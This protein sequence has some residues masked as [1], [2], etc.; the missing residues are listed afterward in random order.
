MEEIKNSLQDHSM[1]ASKDKSFSFASLLNSDNN[2]EKNNENISKPLHLETFQLQINNEANNFPQ[3][4][5]ERS[6]KNDK[7]K[8]EKRDRNI[9]KHHKKMRTDKKRDINNNQKITSFII[10]LR[11]GSNGKRKNKYFP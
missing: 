4:K 9:E 5:N 6:I 2:N 10:K 8:K 7:A 1:T 3:A 11:S